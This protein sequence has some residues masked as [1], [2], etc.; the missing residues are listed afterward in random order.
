VLVLVLIAVLLFNL[1]GCGGLVPHLHV[2]L[3]PRGC[4]AQVL[5]A[6]SAHEIEGLAHGSGECKIAGVVRHALL[7]DLPHIRGREKETVRR[8][9][10]VQGRVWTL[11]VVPIHIELRTTDAVVEVHEDRP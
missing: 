7:D 10:A 6:Y 9:L 2:Q 11:E 1:D 4:D 8:Y 5:V 3:A